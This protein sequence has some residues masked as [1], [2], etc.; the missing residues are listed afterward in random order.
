MS[1]GTT[2]L[3]YWG[4]TY[5]AASWITLLECAD[6]FSMVTIAWAYSVS[7]AA[8]K[9]FWLPSD[10]T[11]ISISGP[12]DRCATIISPAAIHSTTP[13]IPYQSCTVTTIRTNH[14]TIIKQINS[15]VQSKCSAFQKL[16]SMFVP[17]DGQLRNCGSIPGRGKRLYPSLKCPD[18]VRGPSRLLLNV[19]LVVLSLGVR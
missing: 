15:T 5:L 17:W 12:P 2:L 8:R 19:C 13:V 1:W 3:Q 11:I 9:P 14:L 6:N 7:S 10:S 18:Y 4:F 16:L